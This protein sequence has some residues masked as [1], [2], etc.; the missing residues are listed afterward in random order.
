[1]VE[2]VTVVIAP[3]R[4]RVTGFPPSS[5]LANLCA[6][7]ANT[8]IVRDRRERKILFT[9]FV[10][11]TYLWYADIPSNIVAANYATPQAYF[12][13]LKTPKLTAS[14]KPVDQFHWSQTTASW[15]AQSQGIA[16]DYGIQWAAQASAPPR[17]WI[18]AEVAAGSPADKAGIKRGD[19]LLAVDGVD[20]VND[21]IHRRCQD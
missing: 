3:L 16:Q 10:D 2:A 20:F 14:G 7:R 5:T 17:N 8:A 4:H 21:A 9:F 1:V 11:E 6:P 13:V 12:D 18:V 19:R 15:Q